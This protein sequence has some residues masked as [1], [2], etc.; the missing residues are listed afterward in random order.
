MRVGEERAALHSTRGTRK[1]KQPA[2]E[3]A[4]ERALI[5]SQRIDMQGQTASGA[6]GQTDPQSRPDQTHRGYPRR[7]QLDACKN[8]EVT[9]ERQFTEHRQRQRRPHVRDTP[10]HRTTHRTLTRYWTHIHTHTHRNLRRWHR[11]TR[12]TKTQTLQE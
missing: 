4:S 5:K 9:E 2:T 3:R 10:E 6:T 8:S 1:T 11:V 7:Y 12:R